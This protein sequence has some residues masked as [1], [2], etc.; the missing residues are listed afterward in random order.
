MGIKEQIAELQE[1][2]NQAQATT[3]EA[4]EEMRIQFLGRQGAITQLFDQFK[5]LTPEE[6][7]AIG[8]SINA[9]K[10]SAQ[11]KIKTCK[12]ALA[13]SKENQHNGSCYQFDATRPGYPVPMGHLHPLRIVQERIEAIFHKIGFTTVAGPELEDDWHVFGALNFP[14]HHPARDMQDT[15]F[16]KRN[17]DILLRTHTSSVQ[18]RVMQTTK[19]PIRVICPGRVFRN[20]DISTRSHCQ[21]HQIEGLYIDYNVSFADLKQTLLYFAR[22]LFGTQSKIRLRPSYFPFTEPSTEVDVSCNLC[23]GKGCSVCKQSGWL[24]ILGAG[25]VHPNVLKANH[26]DATKYTGFAFGMGIERIAMLQ[27]GI[28]D[29]RQFFDNDVRFLSNFSLHYK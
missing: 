15:F 7:K 4:V 5:L 3:A 20:E 21:F 19:P 23:G 8:S 29:I 26:L 11:Q 27:Y 13:Y 14:P 22:A 10:Q 2:I 17:P 12:E 16:I 9:L 25:M 6:K 24:E 1:A 18:V 28:K